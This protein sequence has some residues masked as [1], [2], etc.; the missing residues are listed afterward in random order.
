[1][2]KDRSAV[3]HSAGAIGRAIGHSAGA[4]ANWLARL[5]EVGTVRLVKRTLAPVTCPGGASRCR[6]GVRPRSDAPRRALRP[7]PGSGDREIV[8]GKP[9]W[10]V[11]VYVA[12]RRLLERARGTTHFATAPG[13]A[14]SRACCGGRPWQSF[15]V[16]VA[17]WAAWLDRH[18]GKEVP[19]L[20]TSGPNKAADGA[21]RAGD[22]RL[23]ARRRA[24][25]SASIARDSAIV[26]QP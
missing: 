20:T 13:G 23:R 5:D 10:Q 24:P 18:T 1:M 12:C 15:A 9:R 22:R 14:G 17:P 7:R 25:A 21:S 26:G 2:R 8:D 4:V 16:L 3:P 11:D 19:R 6:P